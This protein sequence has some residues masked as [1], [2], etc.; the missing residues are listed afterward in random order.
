MKNSTTA[1]IALVL[2]IGICLTVTAVSAQSEACIAPTDE[3]LMSYS[4]GVSAAQVGASGIDGYQVW[5][6]A[7]KNGNAITLPTQYVG[8]IYALKE[9]HELQDQLAFKRM[10]YCMSLSDYPYKPRPTI[11]SED[12]AASVYLTSSE[13]RTQASA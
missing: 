13:L 7:D 9:S 1:L 6:P 2:T 12:P 4:N 11:T 3:Y 10:V 8:G 5:I